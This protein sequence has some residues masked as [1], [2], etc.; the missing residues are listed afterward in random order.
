MTLTLTP[1]QEASLERSV[2][3]GRYASQDEAINAALSLL[4]KQD[5]A[6]DQQAESRRL[7]TKYPTLVDLFADS[8]LKGLDIEFTRDQS[9]LRD[10]DL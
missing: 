3:S 9:P 7:R 1:E 10:I 8:P 4:S 2:R 5:T 6:A